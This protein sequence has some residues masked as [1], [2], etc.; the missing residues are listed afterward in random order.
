[1]GDGIEAGGVLFYQQCAEDAPKAFKIGILALIP[2]DLM[3]YRDIALLNSVYKLA[4]TTVTCRLAGGIEF[5]DAVHGFRAGRGTG[6]AVIELKLLTQCTNECRARNLCAVFLDLQKAC[7]TL[8]QER[9]LEILEGCG[10]GPNIQAFLKKI[11]D[12]DTL[13][14]KQGGFYSEPFDV[15]RGV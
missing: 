10:V 4:L 14:S 1:M 3:S 9:T 15:G 2:K 11:W 5:H 8:D 6:T 7:H 13:V 12:G